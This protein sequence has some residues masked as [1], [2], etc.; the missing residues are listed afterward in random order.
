VT[1]WPDRLAVRSWTPADDQAVAQWRYSGRWSVYDQNDGNHMAADDET[2]AAGYRAVVAADDGTLVGYY[3]VGSEALVPGIESDDALI[4]L[5]VG[6][7][8]EFVG[9]GRGKAFL[10]A[11]LDDVARELPAKSVR[12][13]I[14]SWNTRS[15]SLARAFGF[16]VAG[17]H[18]CGQGGNEVDYTIV[19][20]PD[21][22]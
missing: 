14:Q 13:L 11:V 17:A 12:A 1:A 15:L 22:G 7:A 20:R 21:H 3:C 16:A 2:E 5:G 4:D 18:R 10:Q 8:P 6:M 19:V 9:D